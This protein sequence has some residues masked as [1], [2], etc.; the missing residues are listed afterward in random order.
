MVNHFFKHVLVGRTND[1]AA[2]EVQFLNAMSRP[3]Y[4]TGHGKQGR[5][6]FGRKSHHFINEAGIKINVRTNLLFGSLHPLE[7][8][9]S[10]LFNQLQKSKLFLTALFCHQLTGHKVRDLFCCLA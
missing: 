7:T 4:D 1:A 5:I 6:D 10:P 9:D 8:F 3:S 2:L